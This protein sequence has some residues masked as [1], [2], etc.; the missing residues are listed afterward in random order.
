M[1]DYSYKVLYETDRLILGYVYEKVYLKN[2][3][4]NNTQYI[5]SVYG[6]PSCG[7][8]SSDNSFCIVGGTDTLILWNKEGI[9]Y[10]DDVDLHSAFDIRQTNT[11]KINILIDPWCEKSAI[12]TFKIDTLEKEKIR[13]F[14][15]YRDKEYTDD[16]EW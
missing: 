13:D 8:I 10:I 2:K 6:D 11:N 7:I 4:T 9:K 16:V 12:W 5:G 1:E 15:E 14:I 3:Q